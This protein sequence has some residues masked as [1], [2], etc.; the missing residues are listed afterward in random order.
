MRAK[1]THMDTPVPISAFFTTTRSLNTIVK[2]GLIHQRLLHQVCAV[3]AVEV[4]VGYTEV[5]RVMSRTVAWILRACILTRKTSLCVV[6]HSIIKV[7]ALRHLEF[8]LYKILLCV[9]GRAVSYADVMTRSV[10][11]EG[12]SCSDISQLL[13]YGFDELCTTSY[14]TH[15]F[16]VSDMCFACG[17]GVTMSPIRGIRL[18]NV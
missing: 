13:A 5:F 15:E 18:R 3:L 6:Q 16:T 9:R 4:R 7:W 1:S 11:S 14:D 17:G 12:H 2:H 10:N 8:Q